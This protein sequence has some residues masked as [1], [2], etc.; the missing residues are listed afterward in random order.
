MLFSHKKIE[1]HFKNKFLKQRI[2]CTISA[3]SETRLCIGRVSESADLVET[4]A[5]AAL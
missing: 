1:N 2:G 4:R 3:Q 5:W